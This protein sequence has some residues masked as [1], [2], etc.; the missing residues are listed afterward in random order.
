MP[1]ISVIVPIYNAEKYLD[2]CISSIVNQDY[3]DF[4]LIL[5]NDGSTDSS[6]NIC[7]RWA[8]KDARIIITQKQNGGLSDARNY[9]IDCAKGNYITFID[10]DDYVSKDFLSYLLGLFSLSDKCTITTCNRQIVK[11]DGSL[12]QK[13]DYGNNKGIVLNKREVYEKALFSTI[14]HGAWARLYKKGVFQNIRFPVGMKHEDTYVL[15]DF[16]ETSDDMIFGNKVG[17]YYVSHP[18]SIVHTTDIRRL[19]DL[20]NSTQR[21]VQM[22][23]EYDATLKNAG[24]C[25]VGH[26][27][28]SALS[29]I[30]LNC[31][32][33]KKQAK[34]WKQ[35]LIKNRKIILKEKN[36]LKR[37]KIGMIVLLVGGIPLYKIIYKIYERLR[38]E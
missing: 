13:F 24:I 20:I 29:M 17:Y 22:A 14:S 4:E 31:T 34:Q 9:G 27:I 28:F 15:G 38:N 30:D 35:E 7:E 3:N 6:I 19:Y 12:G 18:G 2:E 25:K 16:I 36:N 26:A 5:V 23:V 10:S 8:Q 33:N 1:E 37:D 11:K 21:L 32:E